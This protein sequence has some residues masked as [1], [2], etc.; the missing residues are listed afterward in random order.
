MLLEHVVEVPHRLVEMDAEREAQGVQSV[1]LGEAQARGDR[2]QFRQALRGPR[3]QRDG[4]GNDTKRLSGAFL[5]G[6]KRA[7]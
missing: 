2:R 3:Q 1:A 5:V 7:C 4:N 6:A